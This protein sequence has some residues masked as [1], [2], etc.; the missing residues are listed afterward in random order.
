MESIS[1]SI[2]WRF[3]QREKQKGIDSA[4]RWL[5]ESVARVMLPRITRVNAGYCLDEIVDD[6][7]RALFGNR[8]TQSPQHNGVAAFLRLRTQRNRLPDL[9]SQAL[10]SLVDV[11]AHFSATELAR[12]TQAQGDNSEWCIVHDHYYHLARIT[13]LLGAPQPLW[14]KLEK[15]FVPFDAQP[16]IRRMSDARWW[17]NSLRRTAKHW[18]EHLAIAMVY[19]HKH[20]SPNVSTTALRDWH[21]Q[22]RRTNEWR[23]S[24]DLEDEEGNRI[25]PMDGY[26]ASQANPA[27]RRTELIVRIRGYEDIANAQGYVGE[28]VTITAP[29]SHHATPENGRVNRKWNGANP[30]DTQR[31][32][33]G[34][35]ACSRAKCHRLG[36]RFFGMRVAEQ[37]HDG[38]PHA[39][40]LLFAR[41]EEMGRIRE[42]LREY[43]MAA[44]SD[45][46][47]SAVATS[48]RFNA[49]AIDP[50]K[51]SA[52][53]YVAKYISKNID[54]YALDGET[55]D[56]S[57]K[58]LKEYTQRATAWASLWGIRQFQFIG[59]VP[60]TVW[61][62]LRRLNDSE[63]ARGLSVEFAACHEADKAPDWA[64]YVNA[65]GEPLVKRDALAVRTWYQ[66]T[67]VLNQ[68][69]EE[70]LSIRGLFDTVVGED[71]PIL[72]RLKQWKIVPKLAVD[73][74]NAD[75]LPRS[76]SS[77]NNSTGDEK[78]AIPASMVGYDCA[79]CDQ[80]GGEIDGT[81]EQESID[82]DHMTDKERRALLNRLRTQPPDRRHNHHSPTTQLP[83]STEKQNVSK[84]SDDWHASIADFAHSLGWDISTGELR[85]L[86]TGHAVTFAG[87]NYVAGADGFLYRTQA[88]KQKEAEY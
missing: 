70:M 53:G 3:E 42:I 45:E 30:A 56:E 54:G 79:S 57:G 77:A 75:A 37:H 47:R 26:A 78:T 13:R 12:L 31:Y 7:F 76:S 84:R 80:H 25:N 73:V 22:R 46:L 62:E 74:S 41:P 10:K 32:L 67:D 5:T 58:P 65:Q 83:E 33:N 68:Y 81:S 86:E 4:R 71:S 15:C 17:L 39:H 50:E 36:L 8:A 61:R 52:T 2:Y 87:H 64:G 24:M 16:A 69:G 27:I 11:V 9:D 23:K 28:F 88:R 19:V 85:R 34:V 49:K 66:P 59:S 18:C 72:T 21:E 55:D 14:D 63:T 38:T 20:A 1:A 35:W 44:D 48:A 51:S 43:A 82:F 6:D 60:V 29:S 40:L